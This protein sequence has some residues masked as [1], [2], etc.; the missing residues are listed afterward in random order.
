[1]K[2]IPRLLT[3][4]P[5]TQTPEPNAQEKPAE[6]KVGDIVETSFGRGQV[7]KVR[8]DGMLE[9]EAMGWELSGEQRARY[10]FRH[11][12]VTVVPTVYY[13]MSSECSAG[14]HQFQNKGWTFFLPELMRMR[15]VNGA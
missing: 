11:D 3:V 9:I 4:V 5:A 8:E 1:M 10:V 13:R 7:R 2:H 12:A 6:A 15:G 14:M